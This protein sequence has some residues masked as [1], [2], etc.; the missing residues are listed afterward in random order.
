MT[1]IYMKLFQAAVLWHPTEEQ[2][3]EGKKHKIIVTMHDLLAPDLNKA[4]MIAARSIP[5]AYLDQLDQVEVI[6]RAF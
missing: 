5:E 6:C 3:R 4:Q 1:G 2:K